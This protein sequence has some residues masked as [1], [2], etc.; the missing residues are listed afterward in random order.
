MI[1]IG[2]PRELTLD[3]PAIVIPPVQEPKAR[4]SATT[5]FHAMMNFQ[6]TV[7]DSATE[8]GEITEALDFYREMVEREGEENARSLAAST[9]LRERED[10]IVQTL[11]RVDAS[12][13]ADAILSLPYR[14]TY[15]EERSIDKLI[16]NSLADEESLGPL[17]YV[18]VVA[19]TEKK[20]AVVENELRK[21]LAKHEELSWLGKAANIGGSIL[22]WN[23]VRSSIGLGDSADPDS[24]GTRVNYLNPLKG[25]QIFDEVYD[26]VF[27]NRTVEEFI[28]AFEKYME[29]LEARSGVFGVNEDLVIRGLERLLRFNNPGAISLTNAEG[30]LD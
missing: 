2:P 17:E 10:F 3:S 8:P 16:N 30:I 13:A 18:D 19:E 1:T 9:E 14:D 15:M 5:A 28:P 27:N 29:R 6:D 24:R 11:G 26:L 22:V 12:A 25:Q 20:F 7:L 4:P 21:W 23:N